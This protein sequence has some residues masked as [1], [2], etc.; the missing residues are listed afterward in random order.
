LR[1]VAEGFA[2]EEVMVP[3]VNRLVEDGEAAIAVK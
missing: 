3:E 1:I 2:L